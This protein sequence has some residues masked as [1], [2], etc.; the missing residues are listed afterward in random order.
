ME[1]KKKKK[2]SVLKSFKETLEAAV[3]LVMYLNVPS[4]KQK[5]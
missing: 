5:Q 4:N 2:S 1:T 3:W